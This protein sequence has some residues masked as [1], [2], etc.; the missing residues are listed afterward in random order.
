MPKLVLGIE[1]R[2]EE[3]EVS[4]VC[5]VQLIMLAETIAVYQAFLMWNKAGGFLERLMLN[6]SYMSS[7]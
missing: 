6:L 5:W 7:F 3:S 2:L 4:R 1:H